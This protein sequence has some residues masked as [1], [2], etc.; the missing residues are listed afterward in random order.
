MTE[1]QFCKGLNETIQAYAEAGARSPKPPKVTI[2]NTKIVF[3]SLVLEVTRRCNMACAHC[4]RGPAKNKDMA[5]EGIEPLLAITDS[6]YSLT[7]SGGEP[8]LNVPLIKQ[9]LQYVKQQRIPVNS[10][11]VVTNG[12]SVPEEFLTAC[13]DWYAYTRECDTYDNVS[14]IALSLDK[15]HGPIPKRNEYLLRGLSF[16]QEDKTIDFDKY[17]P[18]DRGN[19]K[20]LP[21]TTNKK[22]LTDFYCIKKSDGTNQTTYFLPDAC[23]VTA[24]GLLLPDCDAPAQADPKRPK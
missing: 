15:Y 11:Y 9:V 5:F 20:S 16:Y 12:K 21:H 22:Y 19:A 13:L 10:F 7:F 8:T 18:L 3:D 2:A 23:Y 4:L 14:G 17:P 1:Q 24:D 6:I